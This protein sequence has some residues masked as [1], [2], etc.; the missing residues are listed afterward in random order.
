MGYQTA[1]RVRHEKFNMSVTPVP[2]QE[3]TTPGN[4]DG[5]VISPSDANNVL[6]GASFVEAN[7]QDSTFYPSLTISKNWK[8]DIKASLVTEKRLQDQILG[9]WLS[10]K[11]SIRFVKENLPA[12]PP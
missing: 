3:W 1:Y 11:L 4:Y 10:W 5:Y 6:L 12:T 7:I 8:D 2:D 9:K